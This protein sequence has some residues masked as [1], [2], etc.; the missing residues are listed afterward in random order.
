VYARAQQ[1]AG[2]QQNAPELRRL[3]AGF[4]GNPAEILAHILRSGAR[5]RTHMPDFARIFA[6]R[7]REFGKPDTRPKSL[8]RV[9][10]SGGGIENQV[11]LKPEI[12]ILAS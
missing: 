10:P 11:L 1:V 8:Y 4:L 5:T 12:F 3:I 6:C 2:C 9:I 7:T